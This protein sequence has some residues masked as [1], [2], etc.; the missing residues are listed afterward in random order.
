MRTAGV[1]PALQP[2]VLPRPLP[3]LAYCSIVT[4]SGMRCVPQCSR[5]LVLILCPYFIWF[6]VAVHSG[7]HGLNNY[8][9][10][11]RKSAQMS[12]NCF[13]Q[14][15]ASA[16]LFKQ[17]REPKVEDEYEGAEFEAAKAKPA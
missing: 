2:S 7:G 11:S 1:E 13:P 8:F 4:M 3:F 12:V 14:Y 15:S 17:R 6:W 10:I 9:L 5:T 16:S